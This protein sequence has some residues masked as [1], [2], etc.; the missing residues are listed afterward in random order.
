MKNFIKYYEDLSLAVIT[1]YDFQNPLNNLKTII[2]ELKKHHFSGK[3][4]FDLI[5]FNDNLSERFAILEFDGKNFLKRTLVLSSHLQD[6][7]EEAQ[8]KLLLENKYIIED[9]VLSSSLK[10]IFLKA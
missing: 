8:N 3:V 10:N 1:A 9:S 6:D 7:L 4:I 2:P 5:F